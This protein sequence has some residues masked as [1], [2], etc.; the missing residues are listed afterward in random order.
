MSTFLTDLAAFSANGAIQL[1]KGYNL[2]KNPAYYELT[3]TQTFKDIIEKS[4]VAKDIA[5][6]VGAYDLNTNTGMPVAQQ[7]N[8]RVYTPNRI[9]LVGTD[10]D[11]PAN[12]QMANRAQLHIIYS[13]KKTQ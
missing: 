8:T 2:D 6:S 10:T 7:Y 12:P 5:L 11:N 13:T 3:V 4:E 1:I 9:V